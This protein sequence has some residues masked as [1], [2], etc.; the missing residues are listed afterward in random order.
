MVEKFVL[1]LLISYILA[2][3][4]HQEPKKD[5]RKFWKN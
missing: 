4:Q 3:I 2:T 5:A 1:H